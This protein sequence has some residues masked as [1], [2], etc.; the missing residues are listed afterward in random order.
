MEYLKKKSN[1]NFFSLR[2][3]HFCFFGLIICQH[4]SFLG[5]IQ[6]CFAK[7]RSNDLP[8][9][10]TTKKYRNACG[11]R[12]RVCLVW[13]QNRNKEFRNAR[14]YFNVQAV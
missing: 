7:K 13:L 9:I 2:L 4:C 1:I 14:R 3:V 8:C 6:K 11:T 12:Q 5:C 10:S